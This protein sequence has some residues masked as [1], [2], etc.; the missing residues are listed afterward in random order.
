VQWLMPVTPVS[1]FPIRSNQ[2]QGHLSRLVTFRCQ[3]V[4]QWLDLLGIFILAPLKEL[5]IL[6]RGNT[7][8][9]IGT[10][11][12]TMAVK[13]LRLLQPAKGA[14]EGDGNG[15]GCFVRH[16]AEGTETRHCDQYSCYCTMHETKRKEREWLMCNRNLLTSD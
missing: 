10:R 11:S 12:S 2:V 7:D 1:P 6:W 14:N 15:S 13:A 3:K 5:D 9:R 8:K 16:K 4:R